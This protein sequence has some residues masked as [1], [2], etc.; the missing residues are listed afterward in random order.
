[1]PARLPPAHGRLSITQVVRLVGKFLPD[2]TCEGVVASA[3]GSDMKRIGFEGNFLC[4]LRRCADRRMKQHYGCRHHS[5]GVCTH[6]IKLSSFILK[7]IRRALRLR[8]FRVKAGAKG[9]I[10]ALCVRS[11]LLALQS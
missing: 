6:L 8:P 4:V 9:V 1:M 11:R 3:G 10:G 5:R 2:H 7:T